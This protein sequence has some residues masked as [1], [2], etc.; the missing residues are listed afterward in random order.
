MIMIKGIYQGIEYTYPR[1]R[2]NSI[3]P[4]PFTTNSKK[5]QLINCESTRK[6]FDKQDIAETGFEPVTSRL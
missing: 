6:L 5:R 2:S 4:F 1:S 3:P